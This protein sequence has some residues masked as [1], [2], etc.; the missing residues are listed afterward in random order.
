MPL[1]NVDGGE[2]D[3]EPPELYALADVVHVACGGHAGDH[4]SMDRVTRACA[5]AGTRVGA[6]PSYDDREGFGRRARDIAPEELTSQVAV[7]CER[8]RAI[9]ARAGVALASVKPHG[10]LYHAAHAEEST[11]RAFVEG[12]ARSLGNDIAIVG[13][14]G[15]ALAAA[16]REARMSFQRE[17]FADRGV[18]ADGTLVPR[19]EPGALVEDPTVAAARARELGARGDV[20]TV[21]I[22]G[23]TP[24]AVD[25]ARA[26]REAL[27]PKV[28]PTRAAEVRLAPFGDR[29]LR[30]P[31]ADGTDRRALFTALRDAPGIADV[32]LTEDTGAVMLAE[33]A[34]VALVERAVDAVLAAPRTSRANAAPPARHVVRVVYDGD[35]L[36]EVAT[37]LGISSEDVVALHSRG[38]YEVAMLGFLPGFA[39]LR[40][41]D[42]RLVLPRRSETRSRVPAGSVA[43]AAEYTG[44]Y[45]LASPGGWT[46]LGRAVTP[47]LFDLNG[48]RFALGDRV[49]F[50]PA[51]P[52]E[53]VGVAA[54]PEAHA[55]AVHGAHLEVVKVHGPALVIDRGRTGHMHEG[56][57]H[58]GPM[59]A[60][61]YARANAA[62]GNAA[63]DAAVEA[64]GVLEVVARRGSVTVA[65]DGGSA[66]ELADGESFTVTTEGRTR[67]RYLAVGG[68]V[69]VP[70]VLGGRGTL[71]V[72]GLGGYSGRALKRGDRL[73]AFTRT[74]TRTTTTTT[75]WTTTTSPLLRGPD[76]DPAVLDAISRATFTIGAR[77]DRIGTRLEGP[78]L[79]PHYMQN[80]HDR[81]SRPM[82]PG[83]VELTPSGLVVLGPDHPTTGGYPVVAILAR[84]TLDYLM[85]LPI[86]AS[87]Q[88][89]T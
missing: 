29:A 6:H 13:P 84:A 4:A 51:G 7:Q 20:D 78:A 52:H 67:V 74:R 64:F 45:P 43:I 59:V 2:L 63:G 75:T 9:A 76:H 37:R 14:A 46:L 71:L 36:A 33:G 39:Y 83:A 61:A 26:V 25:I 30:F 3:D 44:I 48:A 70:V 86:G 66:H 57:P 87:I 42:P 17:A 89:S 27:G 62:V 21:C 60:A 54:A 69:D 24:G 49:R 28:E 19:G 77:S 11:A 34:D 35:D 56:V 5:R 53:W 41:L 23:D 8:L 22:H 15:G 32:V 50:E 80:A 73:A 31:L 72:A 55:P 82:I 12:V 79:P 85:A 58:G 10:A 18:R 40:G 47:R 16:A 38:D 65:D 68:G 81:R 1:L 88:L